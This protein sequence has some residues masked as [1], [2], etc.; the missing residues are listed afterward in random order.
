MVIFVEED[1]IDVALGRFHLVRLSANVSSEAHRR[2]SGLVA[3]IQ[4]SRSAQMML[5]RVDVRYETRAA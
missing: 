3:L 4:A 5:D 1:P 2:S